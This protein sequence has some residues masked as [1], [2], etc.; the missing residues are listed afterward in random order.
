ME[1]DAESRVVR[2]AGFG[3]IRGPIIDPTLLFFTARMIPFHSR[4]LFASLWTLALWTLAACAA[5]EPPAASPE[6]TADSVVAPPPEPEVTLQERLEAPFAVRSNGQ[7]IAR[8]HEHRVAN[9]DPAPA[10]PPPAEEAPEPTPETP[11][12]PPERAP[13]ARAGAREHTVAAGETFYGIANRYGVAAAAL[14]AANP[15]VD[16]ERIRVGQTLRIPAAG[17]GVGDRTLQERRR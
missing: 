15:E 6:P 2:S 10:P 16:I 14:R 12:A 17:A 11:A 1:T 8:D 5:S 13:P 9:A 4:I 7:R 3:E